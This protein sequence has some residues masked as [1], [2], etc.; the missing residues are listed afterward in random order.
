[1][2]FVFADGVFTN[3]RWLQIR[4]THIFAFDSRPNTKGTRKHETGPLLPMGRL[5]AHLPCYQSG[6]RAPKVWLGGPSDK[7]KI[8]VFK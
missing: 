2:V 6:N 5:I 3:N 1:M 7:P 4:C 8:R